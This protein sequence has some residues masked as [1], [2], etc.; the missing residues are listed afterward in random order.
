G[1]LPGNIYVFGDPLFL[2]LSGRN[3][4]VA[5]HGWSLEFFLPDQWDFLTDQLTRAFPPYIFVSKE[6]LNLIPNRSPRTAYFIDENYQLFRKSDAGIWYCR[7]V[8]ESMNDR[9]TL[10]ATS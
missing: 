2:F 3:Q 7:R 4:A 5:I 8:K 9:L 10:S 1:N 6:Y